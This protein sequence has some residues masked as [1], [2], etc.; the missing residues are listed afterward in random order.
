M[1]NLVPCRVCGSG[2]HVY[3]SSDEK[4]YGVWCDKGDHCSN[5]FPTEEEAVADWNEKNRRAKEEPDG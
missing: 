4:E 2:A 5:Y 1:D 3:G